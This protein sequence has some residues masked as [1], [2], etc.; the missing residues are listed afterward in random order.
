MTPDNTAPRDLSHLDLVRSGMALQAVGSQ[1]LSWSD[2]EEASW[3][4]LAAMVAYNETWGEH[5]FRES[6][7]SITPLPWGSKAKGN[8]IGSN[9]ER[10]VLSLS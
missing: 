6:G 3:I 9:G 1:G 10:R 4:T 8:T 7:N 5:L 2:C